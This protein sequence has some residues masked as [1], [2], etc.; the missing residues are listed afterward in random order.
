MYC[1]FPIFQK[2]NAI[3]SSALYYQLY[4]IYLILWYI[5]AKLLPL[6]FM[7]RV[8]YFDCGAVFSTVSPL[9]SE[10]RGKK[11]FSPIDFT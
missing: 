3:Y 6:L 2:K 4:H 8:L 11:T 10:N 1:P 5:I 7:A 9:T